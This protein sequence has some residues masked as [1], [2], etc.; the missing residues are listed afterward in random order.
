MLLAAPN[1]HWQLR[2]TEGRLRSQAE[3]SGRFTLL[4]FLN[5]DCPLSNQ[6]APAL[7]DLHAAYGD[8]AVF[9]AV[10]SDPLLS[11]SEA[12]A[13]TRAYLIPFP[14]LLD[15]A[16]SLTRQAGARV[17]PEAILLD[18]SGTVRYRGR[19]DNR[20]ESLGRKRPQ[21]TRHDLRLALDA[22]LANRAVKIPETRAAGCA[23][24]EPPKQR[25]PVTFARDIAP[26]LHRH[27]APC[28]RPG[29]SGPFP[30]LTYRDAASRASTIAQAAR[31]RIMPPWL[32]EP[33]PPHFLDERRLAHHEIETLSRW[34]AA[35]APPGDTEPVPPSFPAGPPLG[36]PDFIAA[37]PR[38]Y[39][40]AAGSADEYRCFVIPTNLADDRW[41]RAIDFRPGNPAVVHHA[42]IFSDA[43]SAAR[44]HDAEQDGEGYRC[45]GVPG[46]IPSASFGGWSPG[47]QPRAYPEGVTFRLHRGANVVVQIHYHSTGKPETDQSSVAF[48]FTDQP[49]TRRLMDVALGSRRIDIPPG[50]ADYRVR[51]YFTLP[52]D[53]TVIG[54]IPHAHFLARRMHG[55]AILPGGRKITLIDIREWDFNWQHNY[56]Y[57]DP[58]LLPA[59]TE[60]EM[61]FSYDNSAANPRNPSSP[62]QRVA[63]GPGSTDEMAGLH[64]QVIPG[65]N[66]DAAELGQAL[67]G[68]LM[69]EFGGRIR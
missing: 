50:E 48:H 26:I 40:I 15:P 68:K 47:M 43:G 52:V 33:G 21:A 5:T 62:P 12:A 20:S 56:R 19:I 64:L 55:Q 3:M 53:V 34:A 16:Q 45:F 63:W 54:I 4:L 60:L 14:S 2:D 51:D 25:G 6:S 58:F 23:I 38:P 13:H 41:V 31:S 32:P 10:Y 8:R 17:T 37:M 69:R 22:V 9:F 7:A 27:C 61:E 35:G 67:W 49:P 30:L 44:R 28:H 39:S 36:K 46:F 18:A 42:L 1:W 65:R 66:E 11:E 24:P 57:R 29:Q 59:G